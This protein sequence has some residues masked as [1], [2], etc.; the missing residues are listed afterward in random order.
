MR[1]TDSEIEVCLDDG[2]IIIEPRPSEDAIS[3]VSVDVKLGDQFR[4]FKG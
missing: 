2:T 1:L 3:G 4:V